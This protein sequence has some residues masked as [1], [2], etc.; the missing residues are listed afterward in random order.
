M[1]LT[2]EK[3][4]L[5]DKLNRELTLLK[6]NSN[7]YAEYDAKD[8]FISEGI[9]FLIYWEDF[10]KNLSFDEYNPNQ[11]DNDDQS[12]KPFDLDVSYDDEEEMSF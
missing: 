12:Y 6:Q 8:N 4:Q 1:A 9:P 2:K 5:T 11:N 3:L 7:D 10:S